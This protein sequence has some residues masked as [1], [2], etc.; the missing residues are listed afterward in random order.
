[1]ADQ[2]IKCQTEYSDIQQQNGQSP[3]DPGHTGHGD[4]LIGYIQQDQCQ[5]N[6]YTSAHKI[7][8]PLQ[9]LYRLKEQSKMV[10]STATL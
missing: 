7:E 2:P 9:R 10:P 4:I 1:M 3:E 6:A 8:Q 5:C